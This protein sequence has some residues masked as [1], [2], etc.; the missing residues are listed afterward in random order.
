MSGSL[1]GSK[2]ALPQAS[3]AHSVMCFPVGAA[4]C[5]P[6]LLPPLLVAKVTVIPP[7]TYIPS[8]TAAPVSTRPRG[9]FSDTVN[10]RAPA[11]ACTSTANLP[12][13]SSLGALT[14]RVLRALPELVA[15]AD[16]TLAAI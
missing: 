8:S 2:A 4:T 12:P 7:F 3:H 9:F 11:G 16:C 13:V 5:G 10:T 6:P 15:A 14:C 1:H